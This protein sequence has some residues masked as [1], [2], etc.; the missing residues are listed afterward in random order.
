MEK[1]VVKT[2]ELTVYI[3]QDLSLVK[4][5][6]SKNSSNMNEIDFKNN[7]ELWCEQLEKYRLTKNIVDSRN[8]EFTIVPNLQDWYNEEITPRCYKAGMRKMAFIVPKQLIS[9]LSIEQIFDDQTQIQFRY[10]SNEIE[11][12]EWLML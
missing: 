8:F 5:I 1:K 6:W 10:F 9:E 12:L 11:S 2:N 4:N 7:I 3:Y